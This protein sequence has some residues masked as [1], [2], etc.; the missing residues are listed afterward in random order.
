MKKEDFLEN[1]KYYQM[2]V[3]NI[4]DAARI[5]GKPEKY[6]SNRLSTIKQ[7]KRIVKGLYYVQGTPISRVASGI[8]SP[9][10][11]SLISAF[12]IR[13]ATTQIPTEMQVISPV[14][15]RPISI[16]LTRI[17][18]IKLRKDRIYGFERTD[19]GMV[20]TLEKAIIDSLYLNTFIGETEEVVESHGGFNQKRLLEYGILMRSEATINRLGYLLEK[21]GYNCDT[22]MKFRSPRYVNFGETGHIKDKKWRVMY[23]E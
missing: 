12:Y 3:F 19:L 15:H 7:I 8:I 17:M 1:I 4:H 14:Q 21:Y 2:D 16:D 5:F 10:Y 23:A 22:L 13:G 11:L 9:S 18:F 20:A 6:V